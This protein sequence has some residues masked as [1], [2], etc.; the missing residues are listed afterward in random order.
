MDRSDVTFD[1][2]GAQCAAWHYRPAEDG[3][4]PAVVMAHGGASV[5]G[6]RLD[7]YAERF[8]DAGFH[9]LVFDYRHFGDSEGEPRQLMDI[10]RQ[11]QDYRAALGF[12]RT[13]QGVDPGRV[14]AWGTSLSGGHVLMLAAQSAD[15]TAVVAQTP[16]TDGLAIARATGVRAGLRLMAAALRDVVG[17]ALGRGP[18]MV[19]VVGPPGSV[20]LLNAPG[21]MDGYKA[22]IPPD[23]PWENRAT[24][25]IALSTLTYRPFRQA[26][27][28]RV[29][30]LFCVAE[31]DAI[32]PPG[33]T[34]SLAEHIPHGEVV[35][36]PIGH[37]DIYHGPLFDRTVGDQVA[38]LRRHLHLMPAIA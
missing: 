27:G 13:L 2:H 25:R 15:V 14:A 31:H 19:P 37:F 1:S 8:A 38:F 10:R 24:A 12:V 7:A 20:A 34:V 4:R 6:A 22:T 30:V 16:L 11:L 26:R 9:V 28:I 5:R 17:S 32:A 29:P 3:Q 33:P 35:R 36:Y 18:V 21:A 23:A